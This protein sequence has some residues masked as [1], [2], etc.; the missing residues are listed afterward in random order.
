M[1]VQ[2]P[3]KIKALK[4]TLGRIWQ[5]DG[6]GMKEKGEPEEMWYFALCWLEPLS[7]LSPG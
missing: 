5:V 1:M 7:G 4:P 6:W 2:D 3:I